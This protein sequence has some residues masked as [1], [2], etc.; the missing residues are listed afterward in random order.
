MNFIIGAALVIVTA[1]MFYLVWTG[2]SLRSAPLI[3]P[4][5]ISS[6][7]RNIADHL[8]LRLFPELQSNHYLLWGVLPETEDSKK[9]VQWAAEDYQKTFK[10]PVH[11]I[12]NGED[13]SIEEIRACA[14]PCWILMP[15]TKAHELEPNPFIS[16]KILP[17]KESYISISWIHFLGAETISD[18]C[19][20][21]QRLHL[22]CL[23][24]LSIREVR[25]KMKDPSKLYFFLRKYQDRDFFL[26]VQEAP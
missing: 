12:P 24:P 25:K 8:T 10:T 23:I 21:Q 17:L 22:G 4:T 1:C 26:F 3:R 6:D 2:V 15:L 18:E 19:E 11:I 7:R 14:K 5:E 20:T 9:V 13:A 16:E